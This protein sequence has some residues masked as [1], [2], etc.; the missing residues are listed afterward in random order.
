MAEDWFSNFKCPMEGVLS[1]SIVFK[2]A[3]PVD[4]Y[5][6]FC[7]EDENGCHL[8]VYPRA[9]NEVSTEVIRV[10]LC[11]RQCIGGSLSYYCM[12]P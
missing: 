4:P 8:E 3:Q 6:L 2:T 5:A 11:H 9:S 12:M 1:T 10:Y 7:A